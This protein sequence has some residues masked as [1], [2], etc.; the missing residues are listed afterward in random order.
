MRA[1]YSSVIYECF[2]IFYLFTNNESFNEISLL[3]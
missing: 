1:L 3:T 2:M